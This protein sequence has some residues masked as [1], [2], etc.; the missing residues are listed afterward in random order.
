MHL[1]IMCFS[2]AT[3]PGPGR[4]FLPSTVGFTTHDASKKMEPA[5]SFGRRLELKLAHSKYTLI[6]LHC[7]QKICTQNQLNHIMKYSL[8]LCEP[9]IPKQALW[10]TVKT[11][12][13]SCIKMWHFIV[14]FTVCKD[15]N[16]LQRKK[17][18][19]FGNYNCDHSIYTMDHPSFMENSIG[20]KRIKPSDV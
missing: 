7:F 2:F 9:D 16:D 15:K 6:S 12:M 8:T 1:L 11:Q 10:Q 3:G 4:Y 14:V 13:K 17:Y 18:N 20:L 5:Y 19:I